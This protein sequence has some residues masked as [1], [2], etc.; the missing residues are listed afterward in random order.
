V[1]DPDVFGVLARFI[2]YQQISTKAAASICARLTAALGVLTPTTLA[3][4]DDARLRTC[5]VSA[6]KAKFLRALTE[7]VRTG[8]LD[9]QRIPTLPDADL[10]T[11][12]TAI[13]GIGPWTVDM[14]LMFGLGR[15]DILPV[16]DLGLRM[17]VRDLWQLAATPTPAE[18]L[19]LAEPWRPF[20]TVATWYLWRSRGVVPQ[21]GE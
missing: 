6:A 7:A 17:A 19:A 14:F 16:G 2:I 18:L 4:A 13:R 10:R 5:G 21:S 11:Q 1:P 15:P 12:L 20:R 3:Q 8:T 9:V